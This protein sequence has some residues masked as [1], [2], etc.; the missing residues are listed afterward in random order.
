LVEHALKVRHAVD[1]AGMKMETIKVSDHWLDELNQLPLVAKVRDYFQKSKSF[2]RIKEEWLICSN[3]N[4]RS[5]LRG[6][7]G[8]HM[9][10]Q[11]YLERKER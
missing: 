1:A 5:S 7:R 10:R 11:M 4:P 3:K 6:K 2:Y 9:K 8:K